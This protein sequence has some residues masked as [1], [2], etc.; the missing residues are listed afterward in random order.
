M[1]R[2]TYVGFHK[3]LP[4]LRLVP[5]VVYYSNQDT[6]LGTT[7]P[8]RSD[9]E[10]MKAAYAA[11]SGLVH[12]LIRFQHFCTSF[13]HALSTETNSRKSWLKRSGIS[14]AAYDVMGAPALVKWD[15]IVPID[16]LKSSCLP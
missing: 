16:A 6:Y 11:S 12:A 8:N 14:S 2:S 5:F 9:E 1:N 7:V 10:T 3:P 4:I 15:T 13:G